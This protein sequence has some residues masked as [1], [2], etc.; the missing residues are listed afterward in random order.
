MSWLN[1]ANIVRPAP[2]PKRATNKAGNACASAVPT[3]AI[4]MM[5]MPTI[6]AGFRA[7]SARRPLQLAVRK[8]ATAGADMIIPL[9]APDNPSSCP[10]KGMLGMTAPTPTKSKN[11]DVN[12]SVKG[13]II[14]RA[15]AA[16][17]STSTSSSDDD[18]DDDV[19]VGIFSKL[20]PPCWLLLRK[21]GS[22]AYIEVVVVVDDD[23]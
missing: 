17:T 21:L 8:S 19:G 23:R 2:N 15:A 18:D 1:T 9:A 11:C 5:A 20:C 12:R 14:P 6:M 13:P 22:V 3:S 16:S 7:K 10:Y 4:A